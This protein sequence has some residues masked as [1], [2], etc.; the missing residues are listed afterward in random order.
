MGHLTLWWEREGLD[1]ASG[2]GA[3]RL[4][5]RW[6][7]VDHHG[8][9]IEVEKGGPCVA[10]RNPPSEEVNDAGG[11]DR[12]GQAR[13]AGQARRFSGADGKAGEPPERLDGRSERLI[14]VPDAD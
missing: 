8:R 6:L 5:V 9:A 11:G 3:T 4:I 12:V 2:L 1:N 10:A 7:D 14:D 13:V